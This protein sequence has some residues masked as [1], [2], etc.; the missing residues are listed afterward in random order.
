MRE[1]RLREL[2]LESCKVDSLLTNVIRIE[3][4]YEVI[5]RHAHGEEPLCEWRKVTEER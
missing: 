2:R 5:Y 3:G 4:G 1:Q